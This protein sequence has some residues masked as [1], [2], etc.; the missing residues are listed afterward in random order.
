VIFLFGSLCFLLHSAKF[1]GTVL[2]YAR[3]KNIGFFQ[4]LKL[5]EQ[6]F[7]RLA[8][9]CKKKI[10]VKTQNKKKVE[11]GPKLNFPLFCLF[12]SSAVMV[13][14]GNCGEYNDFGCWLGVV[15]EQKGT[16]G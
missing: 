14:D 12:H 7:F 1:I 2:I 3:E 11:F 15:I 9:I 5:L 8:L 16:K 13:T 4:A 10:N 6:I